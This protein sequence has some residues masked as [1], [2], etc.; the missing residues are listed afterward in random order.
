MEHRLNARIAVRR[1]VHMEFSGGGQRSTVG[2]MTHNVSFGGALVEG[3][4]AVLQK[5]I[6]GRL[7]FE[8]TPGVVLAIDALVVRADHQGIGLMFTS[9]GDEVLAR[10]TAMLEPAIY[11]RY[12]AGAGQGAI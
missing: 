9:Y 10:L 4:G 6:I 12:G 11:R 7:R 2:M 1:P 5:G 8:V 3:A